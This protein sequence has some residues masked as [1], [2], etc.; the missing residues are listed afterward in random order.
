MIYIINILLQTFVGKEGLIYCP[1]SL[2]NVK[3]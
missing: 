2:Y 3:L 1:N